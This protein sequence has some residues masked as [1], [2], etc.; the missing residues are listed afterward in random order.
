[1]LYV[2]CGI[3]F[4]FDMGYGGERRINNLPRIQDFAH[5]PR[6][7]ILIHAYDV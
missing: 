1:M 3:K 2:L 6:I 7:K 5:S 4:F